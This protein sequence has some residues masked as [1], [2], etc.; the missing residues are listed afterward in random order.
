MNMNNF[1]VNKFPSSIA[2]IKKPKALADM[3]NISVE[4]MLI[5]EVPLIEDVDIIH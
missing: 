3:I 4:L 2:R 1:F 5:S